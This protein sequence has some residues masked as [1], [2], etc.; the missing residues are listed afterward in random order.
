VGRQKDS[1]REDVRKPPTGDPLPM[2]SRCSVR[3][4]SQARWVDPDPY[5]VNQCCARCGYVGRC[6]TVYGGVE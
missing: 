1:T 6:W 5:P 4:A 2:C 3:A